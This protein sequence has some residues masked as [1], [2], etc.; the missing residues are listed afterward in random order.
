MY[1]WRNQLTNDMKPEA[2]IYLDCVARKEELKRQAIEG[3]RRI[4]TGL[5]EQA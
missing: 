3:F 2:A 5:G 4:R 1:D